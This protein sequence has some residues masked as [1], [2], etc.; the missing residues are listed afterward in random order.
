MRR[1]PTKHL[2]DGTINPLWQPVGNLRINRRRKKKPLPA[3]DPRAE[4]LA[5]FPFPCA[6][7]NEPVADA[8]LY[9]TIRC[10]DEA[11]YIRYCRARIADGSYWNEDLQEYLRIRLANIHSGGYKPRFVPDKVRQA[12]KERDQGLCRLCGN[13]GTDVDHK[14]GDSNEMSNLQYLCGECHRQKSIRSLQPISPETDLEAWT[15]AK[16]TEMALQARVEAPEPIRFCDNAD[17]QKA[18][19]AVQTAR[20]R[21]LKYESAP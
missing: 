13:P 8:S 21:I 7:C 11:K 17:W 5:R 2:P 6:N 10:H 9:C 14:S 3:I 16:T 4:S 1:R 18:F 15:T 12:V 20:R 19:M